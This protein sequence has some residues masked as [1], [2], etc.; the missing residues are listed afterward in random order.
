MAKFNKPVTILTGFL[1]S[2][3]T[4]YLNSILEKTPSTRYAIIENEFGEEGIDGELIIRPEDGIVEMNNG[5]L[6][7]TLNDNL[8]DILNDLF[9]RRDE[10]DEII[11]E[12]TGLADPAGLAEP[13]LSHPLI[14]EHFPLLGTI[15]LV[16]AELFEDQINE[17]EEALNQIT[18][19]DVILLN[20]IDLISSEYQIQAK[21]KLSKI[22]PLARIFTAHKNDFPAFELSRQKDEIEENLMKELKG[23]DPTIS[24]ELKAPHHHHDH[25]HTQDI[26]SFCFTFDRAFNY[27]QFYH[28]LFVYMT[29]Q[30]KGLYRI[31]GLLWF[32]GHD[33]QV[34]FQ[35]VGKRMTFDDKKAWQ[36]RDNKESIIVFIGKNLQE[37]GLRNLLEKCLNKKHSETK[38]QHD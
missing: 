6:C 16:D 5:C 3:K 9:E 21:E 13:F 17:T 27:E 36:E 20:K 30:S 15:C 32:E 7:C 34:L 1:G 24:L 38:Q 31:K 18:F 12:A 23:I 2:G 33:Q 4:T 14:K 35:S 28:N 37:K 11:I 19:S 10:F 22:N 25:Q 29:F 8:Y 26:V